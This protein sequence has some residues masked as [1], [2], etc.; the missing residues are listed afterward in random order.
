M[1]KEGIGLREE[2][3]KRGSAAVS[4][5]ETSDDGTGNGTAIHITVGL[6]NGL[7]MRRNLAGGLSTL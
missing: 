2:K 4:E 7:R 6:S 1:C 5:T 3:R